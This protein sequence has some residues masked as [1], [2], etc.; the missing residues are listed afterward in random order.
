[1]NL[2]SLAQGIQ[3]LVSLVG[4][5]G[6][7]FT[8]GRMFG[9]LDQVEKAQ[10]DLFHALFEV[11]DGR[12]TFLR[13]SEAE[14]MLQNADRARSAFDSRLNEFHERLGAIEGRR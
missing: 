8:L 1:M 6:I 12:G 9:R 7:A 2:E 3:I 4:F 10:H 13:R 11:D 5:G 14:L